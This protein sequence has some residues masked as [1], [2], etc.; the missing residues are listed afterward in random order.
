MVVGVREG[1]PGGCSLLLSELERA[2]QAWGL[3]CDL[4]RESGAHFSG[5]LVSP[6]VAFTALTL[7][8]LPAPVSHQGGAPGPGWIWGLSSAFPEWAA[9]DFTSQHRAYIFPL[10]CPG[11]WS[12]VHMSLSTDQGQPGHR[13][14]EV[15][16]NHEVSPV[17]TFH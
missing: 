7:P 2:R 11:S 1:K 10:L 15:W 13:A 16:S 6:D 4:H 3:A 5:P 8:G 14:Q 17:M 12:L 9:K